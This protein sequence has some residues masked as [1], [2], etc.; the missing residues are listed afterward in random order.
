MFLAVQV[1]AASYAAHTALTIL[2]Q[3]HLAL[4][5]VANAPR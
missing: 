3:T 1:G 2:G 5:T 4:V